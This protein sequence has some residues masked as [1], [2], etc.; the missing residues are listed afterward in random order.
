MVVS[1]VSPERCEITG[2]Y[3]ALVASA[4]VSSVSVRVPIWLS[5]TRMA[6]ATPARIPRS[7]ISELVT[8]TSSPT[9]WILAPSALVWAAHPSQSSSAIPSSM[10][11][12][13]YRSTRSTQ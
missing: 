13:G 7:R 12:M 5:L 2:L 4:T 3:E 9:N 8:K 1:S 10:E 11:T 6:L